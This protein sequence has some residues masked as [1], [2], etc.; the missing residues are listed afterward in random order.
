[1]SAVREFG[2]STNR[3]TRQLFKNIFIEGQP[4][5]APERPSWLPAPRQAPEEDAA[6]LEP[7][8]NEPVDETQLE[9]TGE[10]GADRAIPVVDVGTL[11]EV[12]LPPP[13]N[14]K[15]AIHVLYEHLPP[16]IPRVFPYTAPYSLR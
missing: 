1:M 9:S 15:A 6:T 4:T 7:A 11:T 5:P 2:L 13:A 16:T 14:V 12:Q 10:Q 3:Q 8:P